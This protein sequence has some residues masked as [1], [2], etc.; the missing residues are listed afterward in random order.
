[1]VSSTVAEL[2]CVVE[3]ETIENPRVEWK[4]IKNGVSSHVY[5]QNRVQGK[6][7]G[8]LLEPQRLKDKVA[9]MKATLR[10]LGSKCFLTLWMK[11]SCKCPP[12]P[13][14]RGL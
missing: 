10:H 5:Y 6:V 9:E 2:T 14:H 7:L 13:H 1:M 12:L 4:K 3:T 11:S 8:V